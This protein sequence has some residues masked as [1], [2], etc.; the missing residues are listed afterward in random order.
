MPP[1]PPSDRTAGAKGAGASFGADSAESQQPF[2]E[3]RSRNFPGL[4]SSAHRALGRRLK[5]IARAS[6]DRGGAGLADEEDSADKR[7]VR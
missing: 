1:P 5:E 7:A 4:V 2:Q 6:P 3:R